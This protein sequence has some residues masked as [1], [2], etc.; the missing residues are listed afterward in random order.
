[1]YDDD[2]LVADGDLLL[3]VDE[4]PSTYDEAAKRQ[5]WKWAMAEELKSIT[6]N[7]TWTLTDAPLGKK[8][9]GLK[10]VF[11]LK[12]DVDSNIT[13]HKARL[14]AKGYVQ[15][16]DIDFDKVFAPVARLEPARFILAIAAHYGW[17]VHHLDV[18]SAF[19]NGDLVEEVYVEQPPA[20]HRPRQRGQGVQAAQGVVRTSTSTQGL[21]RQARQLIVVTWIQVQHGGARCIRA[22]HQRRS[23]DRRCLCGRPRRGGSEPG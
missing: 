17:T 23:A 14:V 11:K 13:R 10:W 6:D 8:P 12:R 19:L 4:E 15:R 1:L 21:E 2:E 9:I 3:T 7:K 5:E 18:K 16:A 20:I 22:R